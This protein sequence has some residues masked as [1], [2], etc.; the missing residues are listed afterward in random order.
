MKTSEFESVTRYLQVFEDFQAQ[1]PPPDTRYA[2]L[3]AGIQ[4]AAAR[5]PRIAGAERD[6]LTELAKRVEGFNRRKRIDV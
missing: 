3:V 6:E 5:L 2:W 4:D 1:H